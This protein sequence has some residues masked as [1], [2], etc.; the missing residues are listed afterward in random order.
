M[1][2]E[3]A[4]GLFEKASII[5]LKLEFEKVRECHKRIDDS[6]PSLARVRSNTCIVSFSPPV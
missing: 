3:F 5:F 1:Q 4:L 6:G 2:I